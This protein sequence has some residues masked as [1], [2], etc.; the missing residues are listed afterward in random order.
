M[1]LSFYLQKKKMIQKGSKV[2]WEWGNGTATGKVTE[3][4]TKEV[5]KTIDGSKI[6]RKGE[7]GNKALYIEQEDGSNVLKLEK[8]VEKAD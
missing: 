4:Y 1:R 3:T 5:T 2:K 8:E 6:T 7:Q